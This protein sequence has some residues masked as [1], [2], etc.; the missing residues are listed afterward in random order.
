MSVRSLLACKESACK[1]YLRIYCNQY[2]VALFAIMALLLPGKFL[3]A[4]YLRCPFHI[5]VHVDA[6]TWFE[7]QFYLMRL[8]LVVMVQY[9]SLISCGFF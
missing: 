5:T 3:L 7:F 1:C 2:L 8:L 6:C 9:D 4:V